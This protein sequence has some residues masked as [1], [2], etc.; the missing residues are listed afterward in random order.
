[1]APKT[2]WNLKTATEWIQKHGFHYKALS[3]VKDPKKVIFIYQCQNGTIDEYDLSEIR[4]QITKGIIPCKCCRRKMRLKEV[5]E[6]LQERNLIP[7]DLERDYEGSTS[8]IECFD[9]GGYLVFAQEVNSRGVT[10]SPFI[11]SNPNSI[12]NV[13]KLALDIGFK[14]LVSKKYINYDAAYIAEDHDGLLYHVYI[15]KML[16]IKR[17]GKDFREFQKYRLRSPFLEHNIHLSALKYGYSPL[18]D[19]LNVN[20][21]S[22]VAINPD[23]YLIEYNPY[24]LEGIPSKPPN[25]FDSRCKFFFENIQQLII[26]IGLPLKVNKKRKILVT[27]EGYLCPLRQQ[28]LKQGKMPEVFDESNPFSMRNIRWFCRIK[29]P[30]YRPV[31]GQKYKGAKTKYLFIYRGRDLKPYANPVFEC[32]WSNFKSAKGHPDRLREVCRDGVSNNFSEL[33]QVVYNSEWRK[34]SMKITGGCCILSGVP[35]KIEVHHLVRPFYEIVKDA[36]QR[37]GLDQDSDNEY[38]YTNE[39]RKKIV[40]EFVILHAR[41]PL[42]VPLTKDIHLCFHRWVEK[43][44]LP[45]NKSSFNKFKKVWKKEFEHWKTLRVS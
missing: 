4:R 5:M 42:G 8:Y 22:I 23:G 18:P 27:D 41:E 15:G 16:D 36:I 30:D 14:E 13:R 7:I 2:K 24:Q 12:I 32:D 29:R 37:A 43:E 3:K 38:E 35:L 45:V 9:K 6:S 11:F 21:K 20:K 34:M 19:T 39:E 28:E 31:K 40:D 44:S 10:Y 33:R 1:M 25:P 17:D 26:K